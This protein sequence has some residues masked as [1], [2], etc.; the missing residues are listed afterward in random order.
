MSLFTTH[1]ICRVC[2]ANYS[3]CVR[4]CWQS[5]RAKRKCSAHRTD[6]QTAALYYTRTKHPFCFTPHL[7]N[8]G[9]VSVSVT[10]IGW[11][12]C[13]TLPGHVRIDLV[14]MPEVHRKPRAPDQAANDTRPFCTRNPCAPPA[15]NGAAPFSTRQYARIHSTF[16][17]AQRNAAFEHAWRM[18][19]A[20]VRNVR[21]LE[22]K[23]L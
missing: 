19:C 12:W 17:T 3:R 6:T 5:R 1:T 4:R 20:Y 15:S 16:C 9:P 7:I 13:N 2:H 22:N 10:L 11:P 8:F 21:T 18:F 14:P 23:C